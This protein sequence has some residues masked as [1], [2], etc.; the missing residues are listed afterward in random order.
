VSYNIN[1]NC[2]TDVAKT[3]RRMNIN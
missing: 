2:E 1:Q 3:D